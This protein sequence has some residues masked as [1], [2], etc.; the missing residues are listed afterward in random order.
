MKQVKALLAYMTIFLIIISF[1]NAEVSKSKSKGKKFD[2]TIKVNGKDLTRKS[3]VFDKETP[4]VFYCIP[5][6][7]TEEDKIIVRSRPIH[8]LCEFEGNIPEKYE[9]DCY[10]DVDE[11]DYA[12]KEKYRIFKRYVKEDTSNN[13]DVSIPSR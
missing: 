3:I 10:K 7:P 11:S 4:D 8:K 1:V 2:R 6:K 12:C 13:T 5:N 9:P